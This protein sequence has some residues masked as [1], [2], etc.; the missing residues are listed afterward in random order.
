MTRTAFTSL[1]SI[2][3]LKYTRVFILTH[4]YEVVSLRGMLDYLLLIIYLWHVYV[5]M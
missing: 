1:R 5:M 3:Y 4:Y 2:P